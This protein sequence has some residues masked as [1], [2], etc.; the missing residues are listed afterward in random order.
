MSRS[1]SDFREVDIAPGEPG[2]HGVEDR[3]SERELLTCG[4][5]RDGYICT[6][7]RGHDG[8]HRA[9]GLRNLKAIWTCVLFVVAGCSRPVVNVNTADV[10]QLTCAPGISEPLARAIVERRKAFGPFADIQELQEV[11]GFSG[12]TL[13]VAR[14]YLA[15][16]GET[17]CGD[18]GL[19]PQR[20]SV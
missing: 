19:T 9:Y 20:Q 7:P 2:W 14:P 10:K 13:R 12:E 5:G 6:R 1:P 11:P 18:W 15:T 3:Q 8:P 4:T 16:H 17:T